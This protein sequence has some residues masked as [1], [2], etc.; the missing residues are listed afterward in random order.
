V[1]P[2]DGHD[3]L[4]GKLQKRPAAFA[5][6]KTLANLAEGHKKIRLLGRA[7]SQYFFT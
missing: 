6:K 5:Q 1:K 7:R 4:A 3:S 2:V